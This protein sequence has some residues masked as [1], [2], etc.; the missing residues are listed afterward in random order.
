MLRRRIFL[1]G[2]GVSPAPRLSIS[3]CVSVFVQ[4][5]IRCSSFSVITRDPQASESMLGSSKESAVAETDLLDVLWS[6]CIM[7]KGA[8]YV[9]RLPFHRPCP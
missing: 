4:V 7:E 2:H 9:M 3:A 1:C 5:S 8:G 6:Y